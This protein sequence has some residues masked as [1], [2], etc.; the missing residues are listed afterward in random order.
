MGNIRA[1]I[2][3]TGALQTAADYYAFGLAIATVG[4]GYR[5]GYQGNNAEAGG[6]TGFSNFQ[7]RMYNP[8][9]ARWITID[10]KHQTWSPYAAMGNDPIGKVDKDGGFWQELANWFM[11]GMWISNS[12][13]AKYRDLEAN[14]QDPSYEWIGD[15]NKGHGVL[16]YTSGQSTDPEDQVDLK[17]L[18]LS[19][20]R[21]VQDNFITVGGQK[22]ISCIDLEVNLTAGAQF[23]VELPIKIGKLEVNLMSVDVVKHRFGHGTSSLFRSETYKNLHYT[24]GLGF[25]VVGNGESLGLE[26]DDDGAVF[27]ATGTVFGVDINVALGKMKAEMEAQT[28][29]SFGLKEACGI[30][31]ESKISYNLEPIPGNN[32]DAWYKA[33]D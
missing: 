20:Y 7:L 26:Y 16:T 2:A 24:S 33:K 3:K 30:G 1:V 10:P 32:V 25:S 31:I 14:G 22:Y 11:T 4:T 21:P 19:L 5:Y 27:K 12:S 9:I 29:L 28:S 15:K 8:R 23:N 13:L 17:E 18:T 6:E